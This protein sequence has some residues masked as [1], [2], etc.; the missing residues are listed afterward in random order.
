[1]RAIPAK[2]STQRGMPEHTDDD[3]DPTL[4]EEEQMRPLIALTK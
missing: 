2:T 4:R 3:L 1:M